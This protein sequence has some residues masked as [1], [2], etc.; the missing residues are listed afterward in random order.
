MKQLFQIIALNL[1]GLNALQ[2]IAA[3]G[4][5]VMLL[6]VVVKR[7]SLINGR[8]VRK[9]RKELENNMWAIE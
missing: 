9:E 8:K 4:I 5:T 2:L 1:F 7:I 6:Q 3:I